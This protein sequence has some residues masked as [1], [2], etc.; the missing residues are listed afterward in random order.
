MTSRG[1]CLPA[2]NNYTVAITHKAIGGGTVSP[3]PGITTSTPRSQDA[4][5]TASNSNGQLLVQL[6]NFPLGT[7]YYFCHSGTGYPTGGSIASHSSVDV[8][9][10]NENLGALCSG[11]GNFW[12]GFQATDGND[13]YSNQITLGMTNA[14]ATSSGN[15]LLVQ[16]ANFPLGT[17]YYFCHSGTGY[18]TGG[19]I[20][21]HSSVDVTSPNENLGALC[22][23]SGNFWIGFQA[24]DGNDYYSNQITLV[25]VNPPAAT[26]TP[27]GSQLVVQL[28]NFPLGTTYYFCHSGTGYPTGGSIASHSSVDVT[29][30]NENLGALCSGSGNFWIGFQATD[31]ND[32]YS[33]QITLVAVNPPA[34]TAT[35]SGSQLV[36]QLANFPLGTTYYF[37]HSG[38]GYPTGGSIASHSSVD[39]TSPNENLGALCS[40]SGN[41]WIGFQATDGNDYY[42]NQITLG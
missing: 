2:R 1:T 14:S 9:S 11:S 23:G 40:G 17:T 24:T 41:F 30:P 3:A 13:Y 38:T 22:S 34:A 35:P 31:G 42:S 15:Q 16:L 32:Y 19:S 29:S 37:C 7:T 39:V 21:S 20:A 5:A 8:T 4:S 10:P 28:A 25:A 36:V 27:S 6:A 33:N 18:P 26:A 12:I